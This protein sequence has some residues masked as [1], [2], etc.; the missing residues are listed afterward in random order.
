MHSRPFLR[1]LLTKSINDVA[2]G[3]KS[4]TCFPP[5]SAVPLLSLSQHMTLSFLKMKSR[6][7]SR[8]SY[9]QRLTSSQPITRFPSPVTPRRLQANLKYSAGRYKV[10]YFLLLFQASVEVFMSDL[11][12]LFARSSYDEIHISGYGPDVIRISSIPLAHVSPP[13]LTPAGFPLEEH[14]LAGTSSLRT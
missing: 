8:T 5:S 13:L 2:A 12:P 10:D 11:A 9:E 7:P 4:A 6:L 1:P 3:P 14:L